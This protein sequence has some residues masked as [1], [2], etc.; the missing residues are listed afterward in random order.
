MTSHLTVE[1]LDP[2]DI[3]MRKSEVFGESV[4]RGH[5]R[6]RVLRVLQAKGVAKLM[7]CH[8]EQTVA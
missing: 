3:I 4:N 1:L 8:Q 7:S 2:L 6:S 5:K